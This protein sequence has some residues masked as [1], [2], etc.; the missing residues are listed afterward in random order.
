MFFLMQPPAGGQSTIWDILT[1]F[2]IVFFIMWLLVIRPQRKEQKKR[3][4]MLLA[5]K[6]G[7]RVVT[8][9]GII[10]KVVKIKEEKVEIK[11]D[12]SNDTKITFLRS[13]ILNVVEDK[14]KEDEKK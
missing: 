13:A 4:E 3:E 11:V 14:E 1:P 12:E 8:N 10:G 5:L 2:I 9:A 6:K 7:D